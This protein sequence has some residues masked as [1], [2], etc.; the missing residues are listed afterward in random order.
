MLLRSLI[1]L[2]LAAFLSYNTKINA[3]QVTHVETIHDQIELYL[4]AAPGARNDSILENLENLLVEDVEKIHITNN[5]LGTY[6]TT[7]SLFHPDKVDEYRLLIASTRAKTQQEKDTEEGE[8][9]ETPPLTYKDISGKIDLLVNKPINELFSAN[10]EPDS[11]ISTIRKDL[12][13]KLTF[14]TTP[15]ITEYP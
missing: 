11:E 6:K 10:G 13:T 7:E 12:Y 8:P 5:G 1:S 14:E 4:K 15:T 3:R 9:V 2:E